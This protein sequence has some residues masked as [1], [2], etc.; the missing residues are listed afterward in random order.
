[1]LVLLPPVVAVGAPPAPVPVTVLVPPVTVPV[2]PVTVPVPTPVPP[3]VAAPVA[4]LVP[5]AAE[6]FVALPVVPTVLLPNVPTALLPVSPPVALVPLPFAV[7]PSV[8]G[9]SSS[10]SPGACG[11]GFRH[12][13]TSAA[14]I[15]SVH[16]LLN[17]R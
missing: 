9:A 13:A 16:H 3:P 2:P 12:D 4:P 17:E 1:V 14:P 5:V 7:D 6:P 11:W 8:L 10:S 15:P